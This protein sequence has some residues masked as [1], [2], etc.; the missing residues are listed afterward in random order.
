MRPFGGSLYGEGNGRLTV[1]N[2]GG[3]AYTQVI[4]AFWRSF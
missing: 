3:K 1:A 2:S 4:Y